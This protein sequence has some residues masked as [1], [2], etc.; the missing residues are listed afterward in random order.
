MYIFI[1][2]IY[3]IIIL[4]CPQSCSP[5]VE[6]RW[7]RIIKIINL[8]FPGMVFFGCG[9]CNCS[10]FSFTALSPVEE[11]LLP[12]GHPVS[13]SVQ[14][15]PQASEDLARSQQVR[16]GSR[17]ISLP[18]STLTFLCCMYNAESISQW[19]LIK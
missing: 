13:S 4:K 19:S 2:M 5:P 7:L 16:M 14:L 8:M 6:K 9:G 15:N 10:L 3:N 12:Q 17:T 11:L 18:I 1:Y